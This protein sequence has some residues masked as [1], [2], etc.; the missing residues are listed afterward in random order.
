MFKFSRR[1]PAP[2]APEFAHSALPSAAN[3][4]QAANDIQRELIRV[5]FQDTV[6]ATGL[7]PQLLDCAVRYIKVGKSAERVQVQLVMQ[8]WSEQ[9][10]RYSLA[11][12]NELMKCLDHYEPGVD[13]TQH[14]WLWRYAADVA[15]PF[16]ELPL[17]GQWAASDA[18]RTQP[19]PPPLRKQAP[20]ATPVQAKSSPK[21]FELRDIF[22]GLT[23][24]SL[25]T[26]RVNTPAAP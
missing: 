25:Q 7:P 6:R 3:S 12:Q 26:A 24:D 17:A 5:A 14:E 18:L 16:P 10:L 22:S 2:V 15:T 21:D 8:Q 23:A 19:T 13:H 20:M 9:L 11:F 1:T 4:S